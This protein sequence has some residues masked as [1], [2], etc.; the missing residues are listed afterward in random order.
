M[1]GESVSNN[2][3]F[4]NYQVVLMIFKKKLNAKNRNLNKNTNEWRFCQIFYTKIFENIVDI[5]ESINL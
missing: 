3:F 5:V 1:S 4:R 2:G